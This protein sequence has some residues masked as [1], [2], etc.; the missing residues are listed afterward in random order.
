[1]KTLWSDINLP[2][3]PYV[4]QEISASENKLY[5]TFGIVG[6]HD[7]ELSLCKEYDSHDAMKRSF[8]E[9]SE[10]TDRKPEK[11]WEQLTDL[12]TGRDKVQLEAQLE[13][14]KKAIDNKL[15]LPDNGVGYNLLTDIDTLNYCYDGCLK[16]LEKF[17]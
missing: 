4:Y 9:F 14:I 16:A 15:D 2:D 17:K 12:R 10:Y 8:L 3:M 11:E 7:F 1:M 5:V 13:L 6:N